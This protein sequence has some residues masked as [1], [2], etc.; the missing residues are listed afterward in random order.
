MEPQFLRRDVDGDDHVPVTAVAE[1][2]DQ[3]AGFGGDVKGE[4]FG[5]V[6]RA[7]GRDDV[8]RADPTMTLMLPADQEFVAH[9][10]TVGKDD[11][12]LAP[13]QDCKAGKGFGQVELDV[14]AH[15]DDI[16]K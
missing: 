6:G 14:P 9:D 1:I 10:R 4:G 15:G 5:L 16:L 2:A 7:R 13:D 8:R 3:A 11:P 12:G